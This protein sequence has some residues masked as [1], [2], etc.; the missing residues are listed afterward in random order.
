MDRRDV[1]GGTAAIAL[2]A[3]MSV[4]MIDTIPQGDSTLGHLSLVV[5]VAVWFTVGAAWGRWTA[6]LLPFVQAIAIVISGVETTPVGDQDLWTYTLMGA[7][8]FALPATALGIAIRRSPI[9]HQLFP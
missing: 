4:W 5:Y 1:I 3:G 8:V 6:L 7:I 2:V 9:I